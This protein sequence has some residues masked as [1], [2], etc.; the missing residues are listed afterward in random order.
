MSRKNCYDG[1]GIDETSD[2][3]FSIARLQLRTLWDLTAS[4]RWANLFGSSYLGEREGCIHRGVGPLPCPGQCRASG[5]LLVPEL[6]GQPSQPGTNT[7]SVPLP[8]LCSAASQPA[9]SNIPTQNLDCTLCTLDAN[10]RAHVPL[11]P[12]KLLYLRCPSLHPARISHNYRAMSSEA[13]PPC[14]AWPWKSRSW[15]G[16]HLWRSAKSLDNL[17]RL[18]DRPRDRC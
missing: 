10:L 8:C 4:G 11:A 13:T 18:G 6:P 5:T 16:V 7:P 2:A 1:W 12:D 14:L 3:R 17:E 15:G 9:L